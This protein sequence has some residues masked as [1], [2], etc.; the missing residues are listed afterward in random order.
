MKHRDRTSKSS[1]QRGRVRGLFLLLTFFIVCA[2]TISIFVASPW[3]VTPNSA[4]AEALGHF[5][6][7]EN[8]TTDVALTSQPQYHVLFSS[9]CSEQQHW[10][11]YVFFFHAFKVN[12]PGN[13][14]RLVSGCTKDEERY[15]RQFHEEKVRT[16][17]E[18]FHVFFTPD[19]GSVSMFGADYKYNNKPNSVYLWM[20]DTLGPTTDVEDDIIFLLDPDMILLRPLLHDFTGQEMIYASAVNMGASRPFNRSTGVVQHGMPMAQQDGYLSNEWMHFNASYITG[21]RKFPKFAPLDGSLFWNSGP[22]YLSTVRDM[23]K[24][25]ALWKDYVPRVYT[26]YPELFAEM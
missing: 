8:L 18:R 5:R 15:L 17:S 3:R 23:R 1:H 11:S 16:M 2:V 9:G 22:P 12:Q 20:R 25:V 4:I 19:F 7:F 14:T 26:E 21:D 24:M 6:I 10:E 13:V